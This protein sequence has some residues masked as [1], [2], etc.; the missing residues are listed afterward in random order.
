MKRVASPST[1]PGPRV[2]GLE[3]ILDA[4]SFPIVFQKSE[5]SSRY[6][7]GITMG[8]SPPLPLLRVEQ[9][10][11]DWRRMKTEM[12]MGQVGGTVRGV[13]NIHTDLGMGEL[14]DKGYEMILNSTGC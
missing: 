5:T 9:Q 12:R 11:G 2:S 13:E 14:G 8:W 4:H 3:S 7:L 6:L 1:L 10:C